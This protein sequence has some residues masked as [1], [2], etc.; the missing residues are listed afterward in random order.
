MSDTIKRDNSPKPLGEMPFSS[1]SGATDK[2]KA[3]R[4]QSSGRSSW[5]IVNAVSDKIEFQ[6]LSSTNRIA[7]LLL[8]ARKTTTFE[9]APQY[10]AKPGRSPTSA[11][12]PWNPFRRETCDHAA[13]SD[14]EPAVAT[15][16]PNFTFPGRTDR[17]Q[18]VQVE[19]E[20]MKDVIQDL[21]M[22][23]NQP[24]PKVME[25]MSKDPYNFHAT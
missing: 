15:S 10:T 9:Q 24:L 12:L 23:K 17:R 4:A 2:R 7:S 18:H 3:P 11:R 20:A 5:D 6:A 19:W 1:G 16:H 25:I 14:R 22:N 13:P 8:T 21:Y